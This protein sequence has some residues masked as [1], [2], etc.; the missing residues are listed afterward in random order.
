[1]RATYRVGTRSLA[2]SPRWAN[3]YPPEKTFADNPDSAL[4]K[5]LVGPV[6]WIV[7]SVGSPQL[8]KIGMPFQR[9][10]LVLSS[11]I[12]TIE[13]LSNEWGREGLSKHIVW[14]EFLSFGGLFWA[15]RVEGKRE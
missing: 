14:E 3:V 4:A 6:D 11:A 7:D 9:T 12:S 2:A 13:P 15:R 1:V 8:S 5:T 10:A